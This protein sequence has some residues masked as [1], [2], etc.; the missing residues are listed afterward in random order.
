MGKRE[1]LEAKLADIQ[2]HTVYLPYD[3]PELGEPVQQDRDFPNPHT[4]CKPM[5]GTATNVSHRRMLW[6]RGSDNMQWIMTE[7]LDRT[8]P[9]AHEVMFSTENGLVRMT[10]LLGLGQG[11]GF[12][13]RLNRHRINDTLMMSLANLTGPTTNEVRTIV[14]DIDSLYTIYPNGEYVRDGNNSWMFM[15]RRE[16]YR[17][18]AIYIHREYN[19]DVGALI[20]GW[21]RS[22]QDEEDEGYDPDE[23]VGFIEWT[24]GL[25]D[26]YLVA[27]NGEWV[28]PRQA[29]RRL[30]VPKL[31]S[32]IVSVPSKHRHLI[33]DLRKSL[34]SEKWSA[35]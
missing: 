5:V 32:P 30:V 2:G 25:I 18:R 23:A 11:W 20:N 13:G 6:I 21:V 19:V 16:T 7:C 3:E 27:P 28:V 33:T 9:K 8:F 4:W 10:T 22:Q 26:R 1:A 12:N 17:L 35:E 14:Q 34:L 24:G 15:D 29:E 31:E